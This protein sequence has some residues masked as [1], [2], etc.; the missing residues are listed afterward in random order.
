MQG[1]IFWLRRISFY[2]CYRKEDIRVLD[3]WEIDRKYV[4]IGDVLGRGAFGQVLKGVV[5]V[6]GIRNLR[7]TSSCSI[8]S[9]VEDVDS[10]VVAVKM[11]LCE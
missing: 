9:G 2:H 4:T 11:L 7:K 1:L 3:Q 5:K 6:V 8:T 10:I